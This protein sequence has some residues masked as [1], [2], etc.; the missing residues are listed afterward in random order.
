MSPTIEVVPVVEIPAFARAAK[1]A[2]VPRL[3]A[4]GPAAKAVGAAISKAANSIAPMKGAHLSENRVESV[5]KIFIMNLHL[6][7]VR[8]AHTGTAQFMVHQD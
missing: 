1:L 4:A 8:L 5:L 7:K 3:T 2:A 6:V